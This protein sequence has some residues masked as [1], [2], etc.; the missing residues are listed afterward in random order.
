MLD[1]I[2]IYNK[3]NKNNLNFICW[4]FEALLSIPNSKVLAL[5]LQE[6]KHITD[7]ARERNN[8]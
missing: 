4:R 7:L 2:T 1:K 5:P 8:D 6:F 3:Q